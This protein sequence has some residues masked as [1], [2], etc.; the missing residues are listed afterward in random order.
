MLPIEKL[1]QLSRRYRDLDE[2]LCRP[3][4]LSDRSQLSKLN[5]ERADLDPI[6]T[7][8]AK[9]LALEKK[10]PRSIQGD[11]DSPCESIIRNARDLEPIAIGKKW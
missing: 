1:E 4:V 10:I 11:G 8:F 5:K 6:V 9:Y 3:D 7:G 2:L